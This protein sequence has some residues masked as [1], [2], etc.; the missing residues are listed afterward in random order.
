M[1]GCPGTTEGGCRCPEHHPGLGA[2]SRDP[3]AF[4][5]ALAPLRS[6]RLRVVTMPASL[7]GEFECTGLMTCPCRDCDDARQVAARI[8]LNAQ[9]RQPWEPKPARRAA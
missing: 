2:Y 6:V 8:Q 7:T 1:S 9:K 5:K 3:I 4:E